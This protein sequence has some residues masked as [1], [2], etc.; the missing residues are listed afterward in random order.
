MKT[1]SKK[2]K[3]TIQPFV[4]AVLVFV[5]IKDDD[6]FPDYKRGIIGDNHRWVKPTIVSNTED[7]KAGDMVFDCITKEIYPSKTSRMGSYEAKV[8]IPSDE[9]PIEI[10]YEIEEGIYKEGDIVIVIP[11]NN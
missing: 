11:K 2:L 1:K 5:P 8:L 4:K 7:I 6:D 9:L 10:L 3:Y